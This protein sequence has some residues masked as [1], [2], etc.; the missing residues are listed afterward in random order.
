[1]SFNQ[2]LSSIKNIVV[3]DDH[4][5][6]VL[7]IRKLL[8]EAPGLHVAGSAT[9]VSELFSVLEQTDCHVLICDYSFDAPDQTDGLLLLERIRRLHPEICIIVL[10]A[11]DDLV[12]V[13]RAMQLG[14]MGFLSKASYELSSLVSVVYR[15]LEGE[16]YLDPTTSKM[17]LQ[18]VM[19]SNLSTPALSSMQ[20]T[21]RE[22][23]VVRLFTRGMSVTEIAR[24]THRSIKTV[25]TQKKRAMI[26]LGVIN[27]VG[28]INASKEIF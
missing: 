16:R 5:V 11:H 8:E 28:L 14:V 19:T 9:S 27:D 21:A 20:L 12:I 24:H 1:M 25:S 3:A 6:V 13:Q 18:H 23:E 15:V 7:G 22:L 4:P 2:Q 17:L 10:T 26:K